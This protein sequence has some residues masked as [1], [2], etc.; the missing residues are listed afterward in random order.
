MQHCGIH[1]TLHGQVKAS[2]WPVCDWQVPLCGYSSSELEQS[3]HYQEKSGFS[4]PT[5]SPRATFH[6]IFIGPESMANRDS[7]FPLPERTPQNPFGA[8]VEDRLSDKMKITTYVEYFHTLHEAQQFFPYDPYFDCFMLYH[9]GLGH[10]ASAHEWEATCLSCLRRK[11]PSSAQ[12][13]LSGICSETGNGSWK[14]VQVKL[15]C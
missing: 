10:P 3:H 15:T 1:Y 7:E 9:P 13:T 5:C 6:L 8:I 12:V 2:T 4:Y 11:S 14:S